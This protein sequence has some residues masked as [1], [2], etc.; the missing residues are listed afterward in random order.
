MVKQKIKI[1][2]LEDMVKKKE[3]VIKKVPGYYILG[4]RAVLTTHEV[5]DYLR[6]FGVP[7]EVII[8]Y[9]PQIKA[10]VYGD[11]LVMSW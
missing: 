10:M 11:E 2:N 4:D 1:S 9:Y 6:N 8:K 5:I 7:D 3:V